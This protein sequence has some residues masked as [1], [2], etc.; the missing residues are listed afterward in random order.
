[1]KLRTVFSSLSLFVTGFGVY[2]QV[3]TPYS[4]YGYGTLSDNATSMQRQMGGV[5]VV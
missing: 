5:G 1:M 2:G 3:N 4:M